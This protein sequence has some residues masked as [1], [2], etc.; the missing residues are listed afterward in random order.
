MAGNGN[1]NCV[2]CAGLGDR[3]HS[4]GLADLLGDVGVT[5]SPASRYAAQHFPYAV[6]KGCAPNIERQ[7]ETDTRRL[8]KADDLGHQFF[9]LAITADQARKR[10]LVFKVPQQLFRIIAQKNRANALLALSNEN[11]T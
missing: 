2:G 8:D 5:D 4:I 3:A 10:K 7:I 1:R 11:R 9:K 6:L